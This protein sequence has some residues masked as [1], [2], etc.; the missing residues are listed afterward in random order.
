MVEQLFWQQDHAA[1]CTESMR[2]SGVCPLCMAQCHFD[3]HFL[4]IICS[5]RSALSGSDNVLA[6]T[7]CLCTLFSCRLPGTAWWGNPTWSKCLTLGCRGKG[8]T[9]GHGPLGLSGDGVT[10]HCPFFSSS[11]IVLD[12]QYTSST[13]TKFPVKWSAPEVFSYSN[14]STKS[15]VW[16]FGKKNGENSTAPAGKHRGL[17]PQLDSPQ[18]CILWTP[19]MFCLNNGLEKQT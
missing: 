13:G 16:S 15:D 1:E 6:L 7:W 5:S 12:D 3:A 2:S 17:S 18:H 4:I 9:A 10:Q 14:Y 19:K 11:R 8:T